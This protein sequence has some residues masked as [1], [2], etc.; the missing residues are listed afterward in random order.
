MASDKIS[1]GRSDLVLQFG[2]SINKVA[3]ILK[4]HLEETNYEELSLENKTRRDLFLAYALNSLMWMYMRTNG[5][6]PSQTVL[7]TELNKVKEGMTEMQ[8]AIDRKTI[9]PKLDQGAAK[10]FVRAGLWD[11]KNSKKA[12]HTHFND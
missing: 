10:R 1:N 11:E 5:E 12:K 2:S 3:D 9:M 7:K 4:S 8:R 6:D